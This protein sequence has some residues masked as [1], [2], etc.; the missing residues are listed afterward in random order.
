M[1]STFEPNLER[2]L[3]NKTSKLT[4]PTTVLL[5]LRD[6]AKVLWVCPCSLQAGDVLSAGSAWSKLET[7]SYLLSS[8]CSEV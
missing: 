6:I 1:K 5:G 8:Y 7:D 3:K 2:M 4:S